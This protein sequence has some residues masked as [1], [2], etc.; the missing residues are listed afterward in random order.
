M[1]CQ[2]INDHVSIITL[3]GEIFMVEVKTHSKGIVRWERVKL[4]YSNYRLHFLFT[5]GQISSLTN[6]IIAAT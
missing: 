4:F 3:L 6:N 1:H 2:G 5:L